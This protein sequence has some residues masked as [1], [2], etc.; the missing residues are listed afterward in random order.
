MPTTLTSREFEREARRA[1]DAAE[2]GPVFITD[3]GKPSHVLISI[4]EYRRLSRGQRNLADALAHPESVD[5]PFEPAKMGEMA[6]FP[7]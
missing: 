6:P 1:R 2:S 5:I 7:I 4:A 3:S